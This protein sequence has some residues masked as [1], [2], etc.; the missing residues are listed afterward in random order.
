M[1]DE[2][3]IDQYIDRP[4]FSDDTKFAT[5][6]LKS[7][8]D[9]I[10]KINA[11]KVTLNNAKGMSEVAK[12]AREAKV[13]IESLEA[14]KEKLLK[15][16]LL[17]AKVA[18]ENALS[19]KALAQASKENAK[20][21][22]NEAKAA[23][24]NEKANIQQAKAAREAAL[25]KI[26]E[27][28]AGLTV[29]KT[30]TEIARAKAVEAKGIKDLYAAEKLEA[31]ARKEIAMQAKAEAQAR[32]ENAAAAIKEQQALNSDAKKKQR[33]AINDIGRAYIEYSKAAREASLRAKS[34]AITLGET[35]PATLAAVKN[36]KEMNAILLRVD[37][38]V[39]QSQRNVGNYKSAFDGLG[40]SFTQI[41]RELPSLAISAQQFVLAISNNLPMVQ[42]EIRKARTEI[43][44]LRAE[45]KETPSL[46][47]K[48]G[49]SVI[50][51]NVGLSVGI[52]LLTAFSGKITEWVSGLFD[53]EAAA[54]KVAKQQRELNALLEEGIEVREKYNETLKVD[55]G[56]IDRTLANQLAYARARGATD[57][58]ILK[59]E[60]Q[61]ADQRRD[62]A[63][64]NFM[65]MDDKALLERKKA[66]EDA[67]TAYEEYAA[68]VGYIIQ[69]GRRNVFG[70]EDELDDDEKEKLQLLKK[71]LEEKEKAFDRDNK[72]V[73]EYH[74]AN[75]DAEIKDLELK[76]ALSEQRIKFFADELQYRTEILKNLSQVEDAPEKTRLNARKQALKFEKAIIEGQLQDEIFAAK[77]NQNKIF[78]INREYVFKRLKLQ[79]D[80]ERDLLAIR[81]TSINKRRENEARDNQLFL[82]DQEEALRKQEERETKAFETRKNY[83][84]EGRDILLKAL[85][86]ERN[87][88]IK[89]AAG[90]KERQEIEEKY[91]LKRKQIELDTNI[92]IIESSLA[93]AE[94]KLKAARLN[95][96]LDESQITKLKAA[97]ASL[98]EELAKLKGVKIDL[99]VD[100]AKSKLES[101]R[102]GIAEVAK[103]V[104]A[105]FSI[106]GDAVQN[107][108][109][110]QKNAIQE[111]ID[112]IE[113]KKQADIEAVNA[114]L[115]SEQDKAAKIT[116]INARAA[117]QKEEQERKQRVLDLQRARF[118]KAK[119][120]VDI[121]GKTALAVI[122][123]FIKFG[124]AG[125]VLAGALGAAQLA[126]AI[127]QPLPKFKHGRDS[128]PAT[129]G[130]TGDG[131]VQEVVASP[132][133]KKSF[134][135]PATDTVTYLPQNW[136]VFPDI[137]SFNSAALK[138]NMKPLPAMPVVSMEG[139]NN[140]A[141][142]ITEI[143]EL[144]QV[145]KNKPVAHITGNHAGVTAI[146][147]YGNEYLEYVDKSV[148][149]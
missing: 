148:N 28:R 22:E 18:K 29:A 100:G 26:Q 145:I 130:V 8:L 35:A 54:K 4:S 138:M 84:E 98:K 61:I 68:K 143:R 72:V 58:E 6:E 30:S 75:R 122:E 95:G 38:S 119:N 53:S 86:E 128:G 141:G 7:I 131:G 147:Q 93:V 80:Y 15:I 118:D 25:T 57:I 112:L 111:Q 109:D 23:T 2:E 3:L 19:K 102:D 142:V 91:N 56:T 101:L 88:K 107:S 40:M 24:Q 123:G 62:M 110:R 43:A 69:N 82:D 113:R 94:A 126:V 48:I 115:L 51:W 87:A 27:G 20:A 33:D 74:N 17:E 103:N 139:S 67:K 13:A 42:D 55:Y 124:P 50:S 108:I 79:E 140:N 31:Q 135:T 45:G 41:A 97:I 90:D 10:E 21:L 32:K 133:L 137:D 14:S 125:A 89:G 104:N 132:D 47:Q 99:D 96:T 5:A 11:T 70:I 78:E 71:D 121:I 34:Y 92:S 46:L 12:G 127:A 146:I 49:S 83:L 65:A 106:I 36:A 149:F 114:S 1:A 63:D 85:D 116:V 44:A 9:L 81:Q 37:Q 105:V 136:K 134:V 120:I 77:G 76:K 60:K 52:A 64:V 73:E 59:I 117:A 129:W 16:D 66:L 144:K 39:G